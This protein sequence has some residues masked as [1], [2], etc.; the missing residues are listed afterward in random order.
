MLPV[1]LKRPP[2]QGFAFAVAIL[3]FDLLWKFSQIQWTQLSAESL[4]ETLAFVENITIHENELDFVKTN[5]LHTTGSLRNLRIAFIGDSLTRYQYLSLAYYAQAGRW[6]Q[7]SDKPNLLGTPRQFKT[8]EENNNF[9]M[10]QLGYKETCNCYR[11]PG[12][13]NLKT[14][15]QN[16]YYADKER[17]VYLTYI[18][19]TGKPEAHGH[20]DASGVYE[21]HH[22]EA[23]SSSYL[24]RFDWAETIS[25]HLGRMNPKPDYV[26][27]NAGIWKNND[28]TAETFRTIRK[29]LNN[30]D[31][32]GIYKTTTRRSFETKTYSE[33]HDV[34]GCRVLHHCLNLSWTG[35]LPY[36][37][38]YWD[39]VH[40]VA[41]IN[42]Q[43]NFQLLDLL[44][45]IQKQKLATPEEVT[46]T[47]IKGSLRIEK[48]NTE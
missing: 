28:L 33:P 25:N 42:T 6:V 43:F 24:W 15:Y 32:K 19:K 34:E 20:W 10:A 44:Q 47:Q 1:C 9:T 18:T 41:H 4:R 30:M 11:P 17:N 27:L 16:R 36:R 12:K 3:T 7:D 23:N 29:A 13:I 31:I 40:F 21:R 38:N 14:S 2:L 45:T 22:L 8:W 39:P 26:V 37:R 46:D 48:T 5:E 35:S